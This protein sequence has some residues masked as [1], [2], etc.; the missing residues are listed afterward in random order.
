MSVGFFFSSALD[1]RVRDGRHVELRHPFARRPGEEQQ[2]RAAQHHRDHRHLGLGTFLYL[3][4]ALNVVIL[5][6]IVKVFLELRQGKF[7]DAELERQ[8]NQRG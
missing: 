5:V 8:L 4:A 2:L 6:S 3:I 1:D 7:D